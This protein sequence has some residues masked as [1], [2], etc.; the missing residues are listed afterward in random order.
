MSKL[1]K[2]TFGIVNCNRLHYFK[3]CVESLLECT[4]D[5]D[6]KEII[7]VDNASVEDGT[8]EYLDEKESQGFTVVR[9]KTRD[10]SNEFATSL[11][12]IVKKSTGEY[13]CPL[14]GDIQF[15]VKG[16]WLKKYVEFFEKYKKN[17]GCMMLDAQRMK[18]LEA[19]A[20]F[21]AFDESMLKSDFKFFADVKRPPI[22][23]AAD[24]FYSRE[25][26]DKM[27]PWEVNNENHEGGPDSETKMLM[28]IKSFL[29]SGEL[30][31]IFN[32]VP[33]IPV[34][35]AIVTDSR[36]TNARVRGNKRYG[37]YWEPKKD[38]RYYKI[39]DYD[40]VVE[41]YKSSN[42]LVSIETIVETVGF[43]APIDSSGNWKKN[44]IR[45]DTA[46]P[47]DYTILRDL[48]PEPVEYESND[49]DHIKEWLD[50]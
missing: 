9:N 10:P 18:R 16:K 48:D 23:G 22:N 46:G 19:H 47:E 41:K 44:P 5:Y 25:I 14:Q 4:S 39:H 11:N 7:L 35:A 49:L 15:I 42:T 2:V 12:T 1:P 27:H 38:F 40:N 3:S 28:K 17:V 30:G 33:H 29:D 6:N 21:R 26:I 24:V 8:K 31:T 50:T 34:A 43:D 36:G 37:D 45:P 32:I 13:I 20:P